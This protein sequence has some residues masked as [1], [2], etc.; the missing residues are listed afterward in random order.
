LGLIPASAVNF[1]PSTNVSRTGYNE[2]GLTD[3]KASNTKIDFSFITNLLQ[4][5]V[6]VIW[7]SKFGFEMLFIREQTGII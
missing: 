1:Y 2:I 6:E 7:Q 3:N 5:D 4:N